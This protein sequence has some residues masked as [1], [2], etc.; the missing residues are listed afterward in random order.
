MSGRRFPIQLGQ[1]PQKLYSIKT[2]RTISNYEGIVPNRTIKIKISSNGIQIIL[3]KHDDR[4]T[5]LHREHPN[6]STQ[7]MI[8]SGTF[9]DDICTV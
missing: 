2:T 1:I 3:R 4:P 5:Q 7:K 9:G 8:A 6:G